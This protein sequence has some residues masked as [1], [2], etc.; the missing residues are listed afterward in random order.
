MT[1]AE[2][3]EKLAREHH[4]NGCKSFIGVGPERN[5]FET[6]PTALCVEGRIQ[7]EELH[8]QDRMRLAMINVG[9]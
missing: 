7:L 1:L 3:I 9:P 2:Y 5:T 4:A 6:C 8:V